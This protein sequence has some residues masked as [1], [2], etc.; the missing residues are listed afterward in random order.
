M[1]PSRRF[2]VSHV[3]VPCHVCKEPVPLPGHVH[4]AFPDAPAFCGRACF[5][6]AQVDADVAFI[7]SA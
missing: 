2:R 4:A 3:L 7:A 6:V 5:L 1:D